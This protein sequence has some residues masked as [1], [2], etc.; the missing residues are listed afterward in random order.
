MGEGKEGRGLDN[1]RSWNPQG[2]ALQGRAHC[3]LVESWRPGGEGDCRG[4]SQEA[5][6]DQ[7]RVLQGALEE[8]SAGSPCV[9]GRREKGEDVLT[10]LMGVNP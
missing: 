7:Q 2:A 8:E 4:H 5:F 10:R 3:L 6:R 9:I 1:M